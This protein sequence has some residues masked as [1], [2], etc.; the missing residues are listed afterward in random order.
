M[1]KRMMRCDVCDVYFTRNNRALWCD[2][3]K[4][5]VDCAYYKKLENPKFIIQRYLERPNEPL[6]GFEKL[7]LFNSG[8]LDK[9]S[10]TNTR[11]RVLSREL[12]RSFL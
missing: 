2:L 10:G 9:Y 3:K 7:V 6:S 1:S 4:I 12:K 8:L 11:L 5:C